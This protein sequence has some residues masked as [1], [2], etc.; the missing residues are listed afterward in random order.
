MGKIKI[1]EEQRKWLENTVAMM[2]HKNS[3]RG[4][5]RGVHVPDT[6]MSNCNNEAKDTYELFWK[7]FEVTND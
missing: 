5:A 4:I 3:M 7:L 6:V 1:N 2:E